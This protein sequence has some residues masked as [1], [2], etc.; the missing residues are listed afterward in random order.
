M[1]G[2]M[3]VA[4]IKL[5]AALAAPAAERR[6]DPATPRDGLVAG[7]YLMFALAAGAVVAAAAVALAVL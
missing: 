4:D 7:I 3:A 2:H 5:P 6:D 1:D